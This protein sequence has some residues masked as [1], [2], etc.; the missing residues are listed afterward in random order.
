MF[1]SLLIANRGEIACRIMA[2]A[3]RMGLRTIAVYSSADAN[4]RHARLADEAHFI[5]PAPA[6]ESYLDGERIIAAAKEAGAEAIHPGYGFL[7]EN[8]AFAEAC[9]AAGIVFVGPPPAAISAMGLKDGAKALMEKAGVPVVPGY[10]GSRQEPEFLRSKAYEIGYPV[11]I[12]AVAGGGG[13]GMRRVDKQIAFDDALEGARREAEAAFGDGRVMIEKFVQRPRHIEFQVFADGHGNAVHLMERD[14]SLQR[15]HQKVIEEAPAPGMSEALRAAMGNAA[16]A[17]AQAVGYT[18]AGTVEF[19]VDSERGLRPD[20]FFFMEMNTRLQVE[21]PVTE[22]ITGL[23][24]VEL[25][26]GVAAGEA[27]PFGQDEVAVNGHAIEARL[28]AEDP[29]NGFLPSTGRL[30]ALYLAEGEGVRIDNGVRR[31]DAISPYYDPMIAKVIAHGATRQA[32]IDR[33]AGVLRDSL[34]AGP[35]TNIGF[36][37]RLLGLE[38]FRAGQFDTGLIDA[39]LD[40]LTATPAGFRDA[41]VARGAL[42]L[43]EREQ[44]AA[45]AVWRRISNEPA[46]P[47]N[48]EDGF[49][50]GP[51]R[52]RHLD[53]VVEGQRRSVEIEWRNGHALVLAPEGEEWPEIDTHV[54]DI[55]RGVLVLAD[56]RQLGITLRDFAESEADAALGAAVLRAPM[57]GRLI[58]LHVAEG[59]AVEKGRKLAVVEAMKMEHTLVAVREGVIG[60]VSAAPGDQVAEGQKLMVLGPVVPSED[61]SS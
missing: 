48:A 22:A 10:Y 19:I 35:R 32:A 51:A 36:L 24:L 8:A 53:V 40:A 20:S 6:A 38:E 50:L 33:L 29:D 11:L 28:Y 2:T 13:K 54:V 15:R 12:K 4:A 3:R 43:V 57:H 44:E 14:C 55:V 34:V 1:G 41:A 16:V 59:E 5:G 60:E 49:Q 58:S 47:W 31:G 27:L 37:R 26:L 52:R 23:D 18:N 45:K 61:G 25:Q 30:E 46:S 17:A 7:A 42:R 21:H 9:A 56:G 39:Q